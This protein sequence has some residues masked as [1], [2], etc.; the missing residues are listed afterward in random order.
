MK[1]KVQ[2]VILASK[3]PR[4]YE[5]MRSLN[6]KFR[7]A[8]KNVDESYP[9]G[10]KPE[11]V[12]VYIAEKKAK[13]FDDH[14]NSSELVITAD[15][16]VSFN[17]CILGKPLTT[18]D[19]FN[20]LSCLSDNKHQVITGVSLLNADGLFSFYEVSDVCFSPLTTE[21]I[22]FYIKN[23]NPFDK[24]GSYGVQDWLGSVAVEKINGSYTNVMG[25]PTQR[26]YR[27]L[28]CRYGM[29]LLKQV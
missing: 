19:A 15:T 22:E 27:E 28:I 23:Y 8:I 5:L 16:I 7:V 17:Q 9:N 21:E 10:L 24:A 14:L 29:S 11:E 25:L 13:A 26:L 2:S 12:A 4:R 1:S 3:S 18:E 20:M 6:I